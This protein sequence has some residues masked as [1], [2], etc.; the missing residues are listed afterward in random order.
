MPRNP[1][2]DLDPPARRS[3]LWSRGAGRRTR[4]CSRWSAPEGGN[5]FWNFPAASGGR[6]SLAGDEDRTPTGHVIEASPL[7]GEQ[8]CIPQGSTRE[9]GWPQ[10]HPLGLDC[11]SPEQRYGVEPGLGEDRVAHP[12]R[13][14]DLLLVSHLSQRQHFIHGGSTRYDPAVRKSQ[15]KLGVAFTHRFHLLECS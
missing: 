7:V 3:P 9:A 2:R 10:L 11:Q 5:L 13:V 4:A 14:P 12:H 6:L 15:P 1:P 8:K